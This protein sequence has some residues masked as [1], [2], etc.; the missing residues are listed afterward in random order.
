MP[1]AQIA[2]EVFQEECTQYTHADKNQCF[3]F[4]IVEQ[5]VVHEVLV[6]VRDVIEQTKKSTRKR[7]NFRINIRQI[8]TKN[9]FQKRNKQGQRRQVKNHKKQVVN[10]RENRIRFIDKSVLKNAF[11]G[12]HKVVIPKLERAKLRKG[13]QCTQN[14][15]Y[16]CTMGTLRQQKIDSLIQRELSVILQQN[17]REFALG[18]MASV[19][20]ANITSDLS[21]VRVYISVFA[22]K[23]PQLVIKELNTNKSQIRHLLT[24]AISNLRKMPELSFKLD[25]SLDYAEQIDALLKK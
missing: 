14:I 18:A 8:R 7:W 5:K 9:E 17:A 24:K 16:L 6:I 12:F 10:N 13:I 19:T 23:E 4:T 3:L 21:L 15:P 20:K 11:D 2:E 22:H 25:D 1:N